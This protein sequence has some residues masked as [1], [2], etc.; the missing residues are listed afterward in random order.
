MAR[1]KWTKE[2]RERQARLIHEWQPWKK[3]TGPKTS[4]GKQISALN[5]QLQWTRS[6]LSERWPVG[7]VPTL[8]E[9]KQALK[10]YQ[11]D[12]AEVLS[13]WARIC[14]DVAEKDQT[15]G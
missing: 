10:E 6:K 8:D 11:P 12:R 1:R 13:R 9:L 5:G 4:E 15:S 2:Q 7:Y 3:S 14:R